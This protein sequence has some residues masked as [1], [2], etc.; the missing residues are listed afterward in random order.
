MSSPSA[1]P[2]VSTRLRHYITLATQAVPLIGLVAIMWRDMH[3]VQMFILVPL[4]ITVT[5]PVLELAGQAWGR[6]VTLGGFSLQLIGMLCVAVGVLSMGSW[7]YLRWSDLA[8]LSLLLPPLVLLLWN[9][10]A[11]RPAPAA[12]PSAG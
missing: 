10:R 5:G 1:S 7:Q 8:F 3:P 12:P 4:L 6:Y 2:G 9:W 11:G